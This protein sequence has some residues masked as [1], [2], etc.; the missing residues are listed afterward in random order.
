MMLMGALAAAGDFTLW[1]VIAVALGS[2]VAG[3]QIGYVL[4]RTAGRRLLPIV[5][6]NAARRAAVERRSEKWTPAAISPFS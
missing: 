4:G 1:I 2:A 5:N 3:D 6:R